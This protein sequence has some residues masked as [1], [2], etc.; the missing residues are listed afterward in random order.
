M[1][2]NQRSRIFM[3]KLYRKKLEEITNDVIVAVKAGITD[4]MV[5]F[6]FSDFLVGA[7]RRETHTKRSVSNASISQGVV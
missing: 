5:Y 6:S 3:S 1:P 4:P 2:K 7:L